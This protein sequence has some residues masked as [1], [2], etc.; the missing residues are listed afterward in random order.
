MKTLRF[1]YMMIA[2]TIILPIVPV[3]VLIAFAWLLIITKRINTAFVT[4][5]R[6]LKHGIVMNIDF[7]K[8]G[9]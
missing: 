5:S 8:N 4:L 3:G 6:W 9:F 7:I 2:T 1:I